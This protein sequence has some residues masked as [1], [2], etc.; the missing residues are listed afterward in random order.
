MLKGSALLPVAIGQTL[1]N[2]T[3]LHPLSPACMHACLLAL[4]DVERCSRATDALE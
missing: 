4:T 1:L 3:L 2:L